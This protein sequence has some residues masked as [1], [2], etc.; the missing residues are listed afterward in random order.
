MAKFQWLV[1]KEIHPD[2]DHDFNVLYTERNYWSNK[3][4]VYKLIFLEKYVSE[5]I[6]SIIFRH[7]D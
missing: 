4:H 6:M 2:E 5:T 3:L 7:I 1:G